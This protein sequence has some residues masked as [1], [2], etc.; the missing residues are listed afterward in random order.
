MANGIRTGDTRGVNKGRN[1]KFHVGSQ[2]WQTPEEGRSTYRPKRCGN[3]NKDEEK[4]PKTLNEKSK[5]GDPMAP[6]SKATT[7]RCRGGRYSIF[8]IA[9]LYPWSL[10]YNAEC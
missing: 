5:V 4:S 7:S 1:S 9:P 10:P 8:W 6:F 2:V 3:N